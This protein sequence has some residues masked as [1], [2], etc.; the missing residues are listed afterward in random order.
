MNNFPRLVSV[1]ITTYNRCEVLKRAI[2]SVLT[3]TFID[4]ELIIIDDCS[5]DDTSTVIQSFN[6]SR[7]RYFRNEVN[8]GASLGD[9]AHIRRFVYELMRGQYFV[10]LCDDDYWS[11]NDLIERQI[12]AFNTYDNVAMVVGGQLSHFVDINSSVVVD[13]GAI[14]Q[15]SYHDLHKVPIPPTVFFKN[16]YEKSHMTSQ[17]FLSAFAADPVNRNIV[18]GATLFLKKH[19]IAA[20]VMLNLSGSKWQAGYELS[21]GPACFGGVVYFDEPAVVVEVR[22]SNASFNRTQIEHYFDCLHSITAAFETPLNTASVSQKQRFLSIKRE[23]T[24]NVTRAFLRNTLTIKMHGNLSLCGKKNIKSHIK[25]RHVVR[26]FWKNTIIPNYTE[27]KYCLFLLLP[28]K[29]V[30][31]ITREKLY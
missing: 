18:A 29:I 17:E 13:I 10:Y 12:E 3:Q 22:A 24:R 7:I 9:R 5:T 6:D 16:L 31:I 26:C 28:G 15:I 27:L 8:V 19:F 11:S 14:P 23:V 20:G 2:S 21:M 4:L 1:L 25:L 30:R